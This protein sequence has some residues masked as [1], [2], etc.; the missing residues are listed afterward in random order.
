MQVGHLFE[1][2]KFSLKDAIDLLDQPLPE[3]A[4][5]T[6]ITPIKFDDNISLN[7]LSFVGESDNLILKG[8]NL[9]ISKGSRIGII[10]STG[11]GKST[12]LDILMGLL[13]PSDGEFCIDGIKIDELNAMSWQSM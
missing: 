8:L 12:L 3:H 11:S 2:A 5:N 1:A 9:K 4:T 10:G 6:D 13:L 7:D